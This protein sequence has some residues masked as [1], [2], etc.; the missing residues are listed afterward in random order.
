MTKPNLLDIMEIVF[1][2]Q[3]CQ[4]ETAYS[5]PIFSDIDGEFVAFTCPECCHDYT[6]RLDDNK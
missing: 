6:I 5:E 2:C 1:T 4:I 3:D